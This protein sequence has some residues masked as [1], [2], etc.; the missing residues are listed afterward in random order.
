MSNEKQDIPQFSLYGEATSNKDPGFVHIEDIATRSSENG[1][2]IKPHRHGRMF[3]VLCIFDG[4]IEVRIDEQ[5]HHLTGGWAITIPAGSVHGFRFSPDT[6]GV[7]LTL[8]D[9]ILADQTQQ[10]AHHYIEGLTRMASVIQIDPKNVLFNQLKQYLQ[11][12]KAEI[13][14]HYSGQQVMLEWLVR[15]VLVTLQR[16]AD[17]SRLS[18]DDNQ[19]S[20]RLLD[21]FK[22]LMEAHYHEQWKVAQYAKAMNMSVSSLNRLCHETIG[23]ATKNVLQDRL[24]IEAKRKLIY[25][26]EPL[27]Q[28][29]YAL[30]F[31]DPAYFSRFFKKMAGGSP[32]LYRNDN[33]YETTNH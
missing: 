32:S 33:N 26:R 13:K 14:N 19:S 21:Q 10:K 9:P 17:Y 7:I 2:L 6:D 25:T 12:I 18:T 5:N 15:M 29:A 27:D 24:L 30:G 22:Q 3:Q 11:L 23:S 31:K 8:A 1:W 20:N 16:Q 4:R 28:I